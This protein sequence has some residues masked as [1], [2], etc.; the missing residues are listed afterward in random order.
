MV[1]KCVEAIVAIN[2]GSQGDV[3]GHS[4]PRSGTGGKGEAG[5]RQERTQSGDNS[6]ETK[7]GGLSTPEIQRD[8]KIQGDPRVNP[9][10]GRSDLPVCIRQRSGHLRR[11]GRWP[12]P[13]C[14]LACFSAP[15]DR[16]I[17]NSI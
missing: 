4:N 14:G 12:V 3:R 1:N 9:D 15:D 11:R 17:N 6:P 2:P 13:Q 10:R 7:M 16:N 5:C 8:P